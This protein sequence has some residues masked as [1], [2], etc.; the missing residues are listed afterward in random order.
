MF[1][2]AFLVARWYACFV[3]AGIAF[4]FA[5]RLRNGDQ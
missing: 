3:E 2:H 4:E 1:L 5:I